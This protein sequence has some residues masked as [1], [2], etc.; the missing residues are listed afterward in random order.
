V[1]QKD[2]YTE[3]ARKVEVKNTK[4]IYMITGKEGVSKVDFAALPSLTPPSQGGETA[5]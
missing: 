4:T 5:W 2:I 1:D 3:K